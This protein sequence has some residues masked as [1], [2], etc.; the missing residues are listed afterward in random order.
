MR[1]KRAAKKPYC[2]KSRRRD[3]GTGEAVT[4]QWPSSDEPRVSR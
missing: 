2:P 1:R 4:A 3:G